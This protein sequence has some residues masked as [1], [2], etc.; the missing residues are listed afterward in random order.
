MRIGA[1]VYR[2]RTSETQLRVMMFVDDFSS[3]EN[4]ASAV[5]LFGNVTDLIVTATTVL[6][7]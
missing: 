6:V 4:R 5:R 7:P 3:V 1:D 2:N